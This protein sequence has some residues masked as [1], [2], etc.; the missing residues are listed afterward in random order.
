MSRSHSKS[1][2]KPTTTLAAHICIAGPCI[3][4]WYVD[5]CV[6][7]NLHPSTQFIQEYLEYD[8]YQ[9]RGKNNNHCQLVMLREKNST[10]IFCPQLE[11]CMHDFF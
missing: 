1:K 2:T 3:Y 8:W 5:P 7:E 9:S 6:H 4:S 10:E 11:T